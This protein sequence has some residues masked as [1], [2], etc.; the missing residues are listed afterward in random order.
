MASKSAFQQLDPELPMPKR[1]PAKW[2]NIDRVVWHDPARRRYDDYVS[3]RSKHKI[4]AYRVIGESKDQLVMVPTRRPRG[5]AFTPTITVSKSDP[6]NLSNYFPSEQSAYDARRDHEK[7]KLL[8]KRKKLTRSKQ[9]V[10]DLTKK[11]KKA[12]IEYQKQ[13]RKNAA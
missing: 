8:E 2:P 6:Y 10:R 1:A 4:T 12:E 11:L 7:Q 9:E 13:A 3:D 5:Y